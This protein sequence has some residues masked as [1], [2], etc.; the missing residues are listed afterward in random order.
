MSATVLAAVGLAREAKIAA[1]LGLTPVISGA[2][3][4]LL[5]RRLVA[6]SAGARAVVSFGIAGALAPLLHVGDLLVVSHVVAGDEH[7]SCDQAWSQI[8][9]TK[10]PGAHSCV[11]AGVDRVVGHIA[12]KQNLFR[13]TGAHAVDMESHIAA[14]FARERG[15]PFVVLRAVSDESVRVLPP[16]A[17]VPLKQSGKPHLTAILKSLLQE[18]DQLSELMQTGREAKAAMRSLLRCGDLVGPGLGCP[19]LG[20]FGLDMAR[21]DK[22]GRPLVRQ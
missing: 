22:L 19:Y 16:A 3:G 11:I 21:E 2:D 9:R 18:P 12:S 20:E 1:R 14:R 8:L 5:E 4:K 15:L 7:Y 10:L 17:L 6:A 13:T